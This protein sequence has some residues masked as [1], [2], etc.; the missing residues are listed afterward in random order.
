MDEQLEFMFA[1]EKLISCCGTE[2]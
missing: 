1:L 2:V